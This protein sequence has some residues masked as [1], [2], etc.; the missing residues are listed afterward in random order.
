MWEVWVIE[1]PNM[2]RTMLWRACTM[3]WK[4]TSGSCSHPHSLTGR[5]GKLLII[6]VIISSPLLF[7]F[8]IQLQF[9]KPPDLWLCLFKAHCCT[10]TYNYRLT[11]SLCCPS[12]ILSSTA[13]FL[14]H[15]STPKP[16]SE[17]FSFSISFFKLWLWILR[18][19]NNQPKLYIQPNTL[20]QENVHC[21]S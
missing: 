20:F 4:R 8:T 6:G 7:H 10:F 12:S 19:S 18:V 14:S 15:V 17:L 2:C 11:F 16:L 9:Q 13:Q 3:Q 1:K 5:S 21:F